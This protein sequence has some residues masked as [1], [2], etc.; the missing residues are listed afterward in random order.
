[1]YDKLNRT[2]GGLLDRMMQNTFLRYF[3]FV[4]GGGIGYI[5]LISTTYLF[6]TYFALWR[7]YSYALG[8]AL[9]MAFTFIYHRQITFNNKTLWKK[10]FAKFAITVTCL[11]LAN[12]SFFYFLTEVLPQRYAAANIFSVYYPVTSLFITILLSVINFTANRIWVFRN[13]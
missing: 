4:F 3:V 12:L 5:I 1:M 8:L 11:E 6:T 7:I 13:A 9:A 10:R 2:T